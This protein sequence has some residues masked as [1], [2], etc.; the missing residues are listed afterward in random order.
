MVDSR[1]KG[2]RGEIKARD[3][4]RKDTGLKWQRTPSSGALGAEHMLKGDL[5]VPNEGNNF[6]IEVKHYKTDQLGS[7]ILA[8]KNSILFD[9]WDKACKQAKETNKKPMVMYKW[10]RSKWYII[11]ELEVTKVTEGKYIII[12]TGINRGIIREYT[13]FM[14]IFK[15][16][17]W[18]R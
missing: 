2:A 15:D 14:E 13:K 10:D 16:L 12:G 11:S 18:I 4:L 5:Y 17:E 6:L 9:W 7:N 1:Q 8:N 3:L